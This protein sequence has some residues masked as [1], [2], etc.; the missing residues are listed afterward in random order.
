MLCCIHPRFEAYCKHL[1]GRIEGLC[2][3]HINWVAP[4]ERVCFLETT[5]LCQPNWYA[6]LMRMFSSIHFLLYFALYPVSSVCAVC[7]FHVVCCPIQCPSQ[8]HLSESMASSRC[9]CHLQ[10]S[11]VNCRVL[12]P[13]S[14]KPVI[15]Y[16]S[17][18]TFR[19]SYP[20][21]LC[22]RKVARAR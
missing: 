9:C 10:F 18:E 12:P 20:A 1:C 15:R 7:C 17:S 5:R 22:G 13:T 2:F 8:W 19:T 3:S 11:V 14:S 16:A 4:P 21:N 6:L